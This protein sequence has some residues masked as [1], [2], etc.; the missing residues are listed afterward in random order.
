MLSDS[1]EATD[2][3][4][5]TRQLTAWAR[6]HLD[7]DAE[8]AEIHKMP[9]H[10]GLSLGFDVLTRGTRAESLVI[11]FAPP[12]V[13][14]SGNTDV[15]RQ[16]PLL[17]ALERTGVPVAPLVWSSGDPAWFGTDCI[18]QRKLAAGSLDM[19]DAANGVAPIGGD[20]APYVRRAA[21]AL[22]LVHRVDWR[23]ELA[24]WES[25][26]SIVDEVGFWRRLLDKAGDQD[27]IRLGT[28]LADRLLSTDPGGHHVGVFHG[29]YQT[30]NL[31]FDPED[32]HLVAIVDWEIAGVGATGLD[33]GWLAMMCDPVVWP[34]ELAERLRVRS[35]PADV[36]AWYAEAA[37]GAVP[38]PD[39][40]I[41]LAC[42]RYGTIAAFNAH[43]HRTGRQVDEFNATMAG[44][45]NLLLGR[46]L[47]LLQG[48]DA[49][50]LSD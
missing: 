33:V 31:L 30:N 41:A 3:E 28:E 21:H 18:V 20:P 25:P 47:E 34:P 49:A 10:A 42:F 37:G 17:G 13:R 11:R 5:R 26:R 40:Y 39:W 12:G 9:G 2:L 46:G 29:D 22:A 8:V 35:R 27:W 32:G 44:G 19:F 6:A 36:F 48:R 4:T 1:V 24:G 50:S 45:V 38:H 14:R 16:V 23:A 15:L 43:L 7:P